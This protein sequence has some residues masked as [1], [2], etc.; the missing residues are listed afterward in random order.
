MP[1][2]I[3]RVRPAVLSIAAAVCR[4]FTYRY[5]GDELDDEQVEDVVVDAMDKLR[6]WPETMVITC[7]LRDMEPE[8]FYEA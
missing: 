6:D 5:H 7:L 4:S 1:T 2:P 8:D 3:T